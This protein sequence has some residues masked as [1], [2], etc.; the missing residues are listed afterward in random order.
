MTPEM[1]NN[2]TDI[3]LISFNNLNKN[4]SMGWFEKRFYSLFCIIASFVC[5]IF[6]IEVTDI[7]TYE[8]KML[9]L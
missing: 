3:Y 9:L 8:T 7:M 2:E 4:I 1:Q 6:K 5:S